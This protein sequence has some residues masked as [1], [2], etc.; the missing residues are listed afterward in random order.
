VKLGGAAIEAGDLVSIWYPAANR[1]ETVFEDPMTFDIGRSPN[2]HLSFGGGP[3]FCLG[4]ALA[5]AEARFVLRGIAPLL[6]NAELSGPV[7][8]SRSNQINGLRSAPL[9]LRTA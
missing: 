2:P 5:R 7:I 3:H 6:L 9:H 4:G 1:D 8:R